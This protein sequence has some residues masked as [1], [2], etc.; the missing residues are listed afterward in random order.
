MSG[1]PVRIDIEAL[2]LRE[3]TKHGG[4]GVG[5]PASKDEPTYED[6]NP[7]QEAFE[8]IENLDGADANK[9]E[10]RTLFHKH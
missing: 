8:K 6:N 3:D 2:A 7:C 4:I 1:D 9:V 5:H 10:D